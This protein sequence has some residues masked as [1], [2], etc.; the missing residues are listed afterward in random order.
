MSRISNISNSTGEQHTS[1]ISIYEKLL[2][3]KLALI[4]ELEKKNK[5]L[6]EQNELGGLKLN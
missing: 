5:F 3:D 2:Q 6:V 4:K 1:N